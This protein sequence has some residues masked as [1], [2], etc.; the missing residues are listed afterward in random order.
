MAPDSESVE[1]D[2]TAEM[3]THPTTA[4]AARAV[5]VPMGPRTEPAPKKDDRPLLVRLWSRRREEQRIFIFQQSGLTTP[6]VVQNALRVED[7]IDYQRA[8]A[9]LAG[10]RQVDEVKVPP[11]GSPF[12]A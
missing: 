3:L 2:V 11:G 8:A 10:A 9:V 4:S 1:V 7:P 12:G 5:E 6:R